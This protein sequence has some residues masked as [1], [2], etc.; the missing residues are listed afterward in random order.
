MHTFMTRLRVRALPLSQRN[1]AFRSQ[2][3]TNFGAWWLEFNEF[4]WGR[5][6]RQLTHTPS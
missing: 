2:D 3:Q 1:S 5:I 6:M 4:Q